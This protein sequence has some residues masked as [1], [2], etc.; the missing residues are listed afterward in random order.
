MAS[1]HL[2]ALLYTVVEMFKECGF[3]EPDVYT[4][5]APLMMDNLSNALKNGV[6]KALTGPIE[7]GD[8]TTVEKHLSVI[9]DEQKNIYKS[10]GMQ[11]LSIAENKNEGN[12]ILA[13][14]YR[15]IERMLL[16]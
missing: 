14:K 4:A 1:N 13:E 11:V 2:V 15:C 5:L 16:E 12:E 7:R 9:S 3:S 6:C 10:L 8:V